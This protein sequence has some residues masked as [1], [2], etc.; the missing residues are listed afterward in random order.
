MFW[1][2]TIEPVVNE[3]HWSNSAAKLIVIRWKTRLDNCYS[4]DHPCLNTITKALNP[5]IHIQCIMF[6]LIF[7]LIYYIRGYLVNTAC[8]VI[9]SR[10]SETWKTVQNQ[11]PFSVKLGMSKSDNMMK[12]SWIVAI[13]STRTFS[14][15]SFHA[16][17]FAIPRSHYSSEH[18]KVG[19][20]YILN[21]TYLRK[22]P[23]GSAPHHT[24]NW[25][26]NHYFLTSTP[27]HVL[28]S[29]DT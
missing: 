16:I 1:K 28:A 4:E 5:P 27:R 18:S 20:K 8:T 22:R 21:E 29:L 9:L 23:R 26:G 7:V 3:L 14:R 17:Q 25:R 15:S 2:T 19:V 11:T 10:D 24:I 12:E 6:G 13:D